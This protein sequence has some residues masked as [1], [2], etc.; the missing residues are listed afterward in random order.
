M[1]VKRLETN[2]A[3]DPFPS[4]SAWSSPTVNRGTWENGTQVSASSRFGQ[5]P[6]SGEVRISKLFP[7]FPFP[8]KNELSPIVLLALNSLSWLKSNDCFV[9][10]GGWSCIS[11]GERERERTKGAVTGLLI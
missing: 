7:F 8:I 9:L 10:F 6:A 5:D 4:T 1:G 3:F 11:P 2:N